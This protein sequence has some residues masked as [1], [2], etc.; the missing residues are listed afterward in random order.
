MFPMLCLR[1][2]RSRLALPSQRVG[3][4]PSPHASLRLA[5]LSVPTSVS[6]CSTQW[7]SSRLL[8]V[9]PSSSSYPSPS[10]HSS[11]LSRRVLGADPPSSRCC[12]PPVTSVP[13]PPLGLSPHSAY[14]SAVC[15]PS[16]FA[17]SSPLLS[18]PLS[19]SPHSLRTCPCPYSS[20]PPASSCFFRSFSL[21]SWLMEKWRVETPDRTKS[22]LSEPNTE[23]IFQ[24]PYLKSVDTLEQ[25]IERMGSIVDQE[26][27]RLKQL[28]DEKKRPESWS[29]SSEKDLLPPNESESKE[30]LVMLDRISAATRPL[31]E[32]MEVL[33][34]FHASKQWENVAAKMREKL[35]D[36]KAKSAHTLPIAVRWAMQ[37]S[38]GW[39]EEQKCV[40]QLMN[41]KNPRY[42]ESM[43]FKD[44]GRF[45]LSELVEVRAANQ[46][47]TQMRSMFERGPMV[48]LTQ[49]SF[50]EL[51]YYVRD[52]CAFQGMAVVGGSSTQTYHLPCSTAACI[53]VLTCVSDPKLRRKV[54]AL[55]METTRKSVSPILQKMIDARHDTATCQGWS[56][57]AAKK[58]AI[59]GAAVGSEKQA[60]SLLES[61]ADAMREDARE[62]VQ[63]L[64]AMKRKDIA[65]GVVDAQ[66]EDG[67]YRTDLLYYTKRWLESNETYQKLEQKVSYRKVL[68]VLN[69]ICE[70]WLNCRF[71][72]KPVHPGE[73]WDKY[74]ERLDMYEKDTNRLI[75][76]AYIDLNATGRHGAFGRISPTA[77]G[78][79]LN[80]VLDG[81]V[82]GVILTRIG[83]TIALRAEECGAHAEEW[84][85]ALPDCH[86]SWSEGRVVFHEVGHFMAEMLSRTQMELYAGNRGP[87][88]FAEIAAALW[89]RFYHTPTTVQAI[90]DCEEKISMEEATEFLRV[91]TRF[92]SLYQY[93]KAL[94][95][96]YDQVA[97]GEEKIDVDDLSDSIRQKYDIFPQRE[98]DPCLYQ[99]AKLDSHGAQI[100]SYVYAAV[101]AANIYEHLQNVA[102]RSGQHEAGRLLRDRYLHLGS[103][104][105]YDELLD[106]LLEGSGIAHHTDF[107]NLLKHD[108]LFTSR[109][110]SSNGDSCG[111]GGVGGVRGR[112]DQSGADR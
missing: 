79:H 48:E 88:D 67:F 75:G 4:I 42:G 17:P 8:S 52:L 36:M 18:S 34:H 21:L 15:S 22:N 16:H 94:E 3:R 24:L 81:L 14:L 33:F 27:N 11:S 44:I 66:E 74:M 84:D 6:T 1:Q 111:N 47:S 12:P 99:N 49:S 30:V 78:E 43:R 29:V 31:Q 53:V 9:A 100:Y 85:G 7:P 20:P 50:E 82:R 110:V 58:L 112:R 89:E 71:E 108:R 64:S 106:H 41:R 97:H 68:A 83:R 45:V 55:S 26:V 59:T 96:F 69:D 5:S 86:I 102:E 91:E 105:I 72:V 92:S 101:V 2:S 32:Q 95:S 65:D 104:R 107:G 46:F 73:G 19:S 35:G 54:S 39:N 76:H 98:G 70:Q 61:F 56:S 37:A 51:P 25:H 28:M 90:M 57:H 77:T 40:A 60:L 13:L 80:D 87:V 109:S 38:E 93:D 23:C 62:C 63:V 103:A 10:L